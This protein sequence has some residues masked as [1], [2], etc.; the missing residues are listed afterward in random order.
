MAPSGVKRFREL[1]LHLA[2]SGRLLPI[3]AESESA[4]VSIAEASVLKAEYRA[5]HKLRPSRSEQPADEIDV[6]IEIPTHWKWARLGDIACY[7]QRG[8]GPTYDEDGSTSVISQKCVQWSGFD[9]SSARRISDES[10]KAYGQ[11]RFLVKGDILWNSTG[12]GT[13]GRVIIYPGIDEKVVA[14]SHLTIV[15]L[16]NFVPAYVWCYLISPAIQQR[17]IPGHEDSMVTGTTNQVELSTAKVFELPIPCPPIAEQELIVAKVNELMALCDQLEVQQAER[18]RRFPLLSYASHTCF[19]EAPNDINLNRIFDDTEMVSTAHLRR[20]IFTLAIQGK[21]VPQEKEDESVAKLLERIE[22]ERAL[23]SKENG[24]RMRSENSRSEVA[25]PTLPLTWRWA[26]LSSLCNAVT[27]GDHL[28]PPKSSEGIAFLTIG[29]VTTGEVVFEGCRLVPK[30]YYDKLAPFRRPLVGDIVYTVVGATYGRPALV[31][32]SR[33][34]CVQR[35]I[36]ILKP[37]KNMDVNFLMLALRSPF[38]YEQAT[39]S[40]TGTAQPTIPLTALRNFL[41]PVPPLAEQRRIVA[42]VGELMALVD[43]LENQQRQRD[44]LAEA[45]AKACIDTFTGTTQLKILEKMKVPKTELVSIVALGENPKS[46]EKA[47]LARLLRQHEGKLAAKELWRHSGLT[48]DSFYM[49]LKA[50]I[51]HGWIK[52]PLEAQMQVVEEV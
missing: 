1:V 21:L 40:I 7:I 25:A 33:P 17:M 27:D 2:V 19:A 16:T 51:A 52:P 34:F 39:S 12:T 20:T 38:V 47:P 24:F 31:E 37:S 23:Y 22:A 35:H 4:D 15:R 9:F 5:K 45:F 41:F 49:Q 8:K 11:E 44:Q 50:E 6:G 18:N 28:P 42:K 32:V 13:A 14:D 48:I 46:E 36:A 30:S 29:N 10:V 43:S 3:Q 26:R